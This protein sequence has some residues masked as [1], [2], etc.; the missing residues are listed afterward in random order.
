MAGET[1]YTDLDECI[2][3]LKEMGITRIAL[4]EIRERRPQFVESKEPDTMGVLDVIVVKRAEVLAYRESHIYKC[5]VDNV[6]PEEVYNRLTAE[7]FEV[8]R[9]SRNMI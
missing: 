4:A 7:G 9:R 6:E 2:R 3:A 5:V 1:I 8:K